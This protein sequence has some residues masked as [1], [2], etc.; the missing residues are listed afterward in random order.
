MA[1]TLRALCKIRAGQ[2]PALISASSSS[3]RVGKKT[4][5]SLY[6]GNP[7][8]DKSDLHIRV[9]VD[10]LS[11]NSCDSRRVPQRRSHLPYGLTDDDL[12]RLLGGDIRRSSI[13]VI[14]PGFGQHA[15]LGGLGLLSL[16]S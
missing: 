16:L 5:L 3:K 11:T 10:L 13:R 12:Q 2:G 15:L 6:I 14:L 8:S 9:K 4:R 7:A 1:Y